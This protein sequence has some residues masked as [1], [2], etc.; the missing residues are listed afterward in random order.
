MYSKSMLF[1]LKYTKFK[2]KHNFLHRFNY[3]FR[4]GEFS[5]L[6]LIE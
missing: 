2:T 4:G 5:F 1:E 6:T 3:V